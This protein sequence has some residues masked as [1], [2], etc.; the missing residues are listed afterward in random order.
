[1]PRVMG[2]LLLAG[3]LGVAACGKASEPRSSSGAVVFAEECQTCHTLV[4]NESRRT[5]GGDLMGYR[6]NR[7][8][9]AQFTREMPVRHPLSPAELSAVVN[10]LLRAERH[11]SG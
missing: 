7:A 4:G 2:W 11:G 1:M 9:L 8:T 6:L 3:V 10:L 5:Q